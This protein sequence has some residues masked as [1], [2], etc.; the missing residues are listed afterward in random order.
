LNNENKNINK[1]KE[2]VKQEK[3]NKKN[4]SYRYLKRRRRYQQKKW[5]W[6]IN[7]FNVS[8]FYAIFIWKYLLITKTF[9]DIMI[10]LYYYLYFELD[11]V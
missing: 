7:I 1:E 11:F 4:R 5:W 8:L 3:N 10:P 9:P 2:D 6:K